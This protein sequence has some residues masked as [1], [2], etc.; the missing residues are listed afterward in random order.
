[1]LRL[2]WEEGGEAWRWRMRLF[3]W[4]EE[5]VR[6]CV[7]LLHNTVLQIDTLDRWRLLL[8]RVNGYS[9]WLKVSLFAWRLLHNMLPTRD[10]LVRQRVLQDDDIVCVGG[11]GGTF[12]FGVQPIRQPLVSHLEVIRHYYG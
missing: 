1:M 10:D 5:N 3:A 6:E 11:C 8:D 12:V 2:G 4:E 7:F 9:V